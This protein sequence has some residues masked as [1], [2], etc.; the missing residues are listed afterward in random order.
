L[1][2]GDHPDDAPVCLVA[3]NFIFDIQTYKDTNY[4]IEKG[5]TPPKHVENEMIAA[6]KV[7]PE[8]AREI[9]EK[10]HRQEK[11]LVEVYIATENKDV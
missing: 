6:C 3:N 1:G 10:E 9:L 2:S 7:T 11:P 4:F 8:E 5:G